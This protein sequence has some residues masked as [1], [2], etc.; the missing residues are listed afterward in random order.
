MNIIVDK[1]INNSIYV[2]NINNHA[3]KSDDIIKFV[4]FQYMSPIDKYLTIVSAGL[5]LNKVEAAVLKH[6]INNNGTEL[7]GQVCIAVAKEVNKSTATIVRAI[8]TL[9]NEKLIYGDG[10]KALKLSATIDADI[11]AINKA[12]FFVIE[13]NPE[14]T[15]PKIEL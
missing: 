13:V 12:K 7:S 11:K 4:C 6:I 14:V 2:D 10:A 15:S 5:N 8:N 3:A 1:R 9:R